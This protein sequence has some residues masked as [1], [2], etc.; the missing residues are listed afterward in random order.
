MRHVLGIQSILAGL[1]VLATPI[2]AAQAGGGCDPA[3][4]T[5]PSL[6][7]FADAA[8]TQT[9]ATLAPGTLT[10]LF[11]YAFPRGDVADGISGVEFR[12]VV[13]HPA[14]YLFSY[15]APAGAALTFGDPVDALP[16]DQLDPVGLNVAFS[17]CQPGAR[18]PMGTLTVINLGNGG[19]TELR[20]QRR[21]PAANTSF[22]APLVVGC[23]EPFFS[24]TCLRAC[25]FDEHGSVIAARLHLNDPLCDPAVDCPPACASA[26]CVSLSAASF[27]MGCIGEPFTVTGTATNCSQSIEDIDVFVEHALAGHFTGVAPGQHVVASRTYTL[28]NCRSASIDIGALA[29]SHGC[30]SPAGAEIARDP[31]CTSCGV[32]TPPDCSNAALS[33]STLWPPDGR[34]VPI[35][36]GGVVDPDGGPIAYEIQAILSDE[37]AGRANS[38]LCPD[39]L[40]DGPTSFRLRAERQSNGDG[41]VYRLFLRAA[42]TRGA[43]CNS[44]MDVCVPRKPGVLCG[45]EDRLVYSATACESSPLG[46]RRGGVVAYPASAGALDVIVEDID[47]QEARVEVFD[48]RG[49]RVALLAQSRFGAG[50]HV[51]HWNGTDTAGHA[52]AAGI[53]VVRVRAGTTEITTKAALLR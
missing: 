43:E 52:V 3:A 24:K 19:P 27:V 45:S 23:D 26:N 42:D 28:Q 1:L 39:A 14:G 49:R 47:G 48:V 4:A 2:Q 46:N 21:D 17:N 31:V 13:T 22:N 34:M 18:L 38:A 11:L 8:G 41:R 35:E 33:V 32:N 25:S 5:S 9:C 50:R 16:D 20:V 12:I 10:T 40:I 53:Y 15:T 44:T 6:G 51:L 7:L 37:P 30:L 36:V 29:R